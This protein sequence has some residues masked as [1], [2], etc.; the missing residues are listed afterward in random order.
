VTGRFDPGLDPGLGTGAEPGVQPGAGSE[1][2]AGRP[3]SAAGGRSRPL[4]VT[5]VAPAGVV[6]GAELWLLAMLA[7]TDRLDADAV[8]L[9][10]GP[11]VEEF[12]RLGVPARVLPTGRRPVDL[13]RS[14]T[15]LARLLRADR[16][17]PDVV[18]ANGVKAAVVA[19]PAARLAAVRCVAVKH[20]HSYDGP[21][22][23]VLARLVD[24]VVA[25]SPTLAAAAGRADVAVVPP[26]RPPRPLPRE[27]ARLMLAGYGLDP[28]DPRPVLAV[29]GR[30]VR[31]KGVEDALLA[32]TRPG[33]ENWRLLVVGDADPAEPAEPDRL[34]AITEAAGLTDRVVFAGAVPGA[35][36]LLT[37]VDAVA[38]LTKPSGAGPD[39]EGFGAV[40]LEAMVAGVPVIATEPGPVAGRLAG[41]AGLV[42]PPGA[43]ARVATALGRLAN[44]STRAAMGAAGIR[45]TRDH[46]TGRGCATLL[47]R[48]LARVAGRPGAG[49]LTGDGAPIS[50]VVTVLNEADT[51]DRLLGAL[52]AQL[53][54]P[55]DEIV[56]V[57]GG[58]RDRTVGLVQAWTRRE[59]R[60]RLLI[61]PTLGISAGRNA[62][63][64]EAANGLVACTDAGC[65]PAPGWLAALRAA[66]ADGDPPGLLT[67]VYRVRGD[68]AI[69]AALAAVGYPDPAEQRRP[70]LLVRAYGRLF[71]RTFDP[72]M[73]TGRSMAFPVAAWAE[74]RGFPE[75]LQTGEDVL[76]GR[77]LVT[78]GHP[79]VLVGEAEVS[80][81]QRPTIAGTARMYFRYGQGSGR[82]RD[83]RLLRRDLARVAGY[84][85]APWLL[86]RGRPATRLAA[87]AAAAGYLSLPLARVLR[88]PAEPAVGVSV[89]GVSAA[90]A[91][92]ASGRVEAGPHPAERRLRQVRGCLR[93]PRVTRL[94][95]VAAV[96][97]AAAL[98]DLAKAAGAVHGLAVGSTIRPARRRR[99]GG[100]RRPPGRPDAR[101]G[102]PLGPVEVHLEPP[103]AGDPTG[104]H[105]A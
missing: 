71:G 77:S 94:L 46:P 97:A 1:V 61:R 5:V 104:R 8:L 105:S 99:R 40:A 42:V 85:S 48:E 33:G 47:A 15:R 51:I 84:L 87:L 9:A 56:I 3:A 102:A 75:H 90:A 18:L 54:H 72:T 88:A 78:A 28:H 12:A 103:G 91:A 74:V 25:T 38:V 41:E 50:I 100:T 57:D 11:L 68:G 17:P 82:S 76:F 27:T 65:E 49:L 45:L 20:D 16:R 81:S 44:P 4:R 95:A 96:P 98:R 55:Q 60:V 39:R 52:V 36:G 63:I 22:V 83:P 101:S 19:A 2:A 29:V 21:L 34:R 32:L 69:R 23:N 70:T 64:R 6:G 59:P 24:G 80:W 86:L 67:G 79:A 13:A 43:P 37:G 93:G 35:A 73:P 53:G 31:Y 10:N 26:P 89:V 30:L 58:S 62:G 7:G 14:A 66:A 92:E